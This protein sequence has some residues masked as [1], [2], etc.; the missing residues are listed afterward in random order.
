MPKLYKM[1]LL[2]LILFV[3]SLN[4]SCKK[5]SIHGVN[6]IGEW[7]VI[8]DDCVK[9]M[10]YEF[11]EGNTLIFRHTESSNY[12]DTA[13][14]DLHF[15]KIEIEYLD[16]IDNYTVIKYSE[17]EIEIMGFTTSNIPEVINTRLKRIND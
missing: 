9:C 8:G 14:Y 15:N 10:I 2:L 3:L 1:R 12:N 6:I 5:T 17:D 7:F 16:K 13:N 11:S 4:M